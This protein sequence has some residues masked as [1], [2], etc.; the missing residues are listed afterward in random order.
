MYVSLCICLYL[1]LYTYIYI[2]VYTHVYAYQDEY[3]CLRGS[4]EIDG[5]MADAGKTTQ[6]VTGVSA[7]AICFNMQAARS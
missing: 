7:L 5:L 6:P 3:M 4:R 1:C 2:Y